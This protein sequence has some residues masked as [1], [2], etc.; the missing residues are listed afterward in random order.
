MAF[1]SIIQ[2]ITDYVCDYKIE[3]EIAINTAYYDLLDSIACALMALKFP[4]CTKLL[5]PI[6]PGASLKNGARVPGTDFELDPV[7]AAFNIGTLIRWLDF[8]DT[9]LAAEWGH[10]SDNLGGILAVCDYLNRCEGKN[11]TVHDI[12]IAMIKAHEIQGVLALDNSFNR[13]GLDHVI[14]VKVATTAVVSHLLGCTRDQINNAVSNAFVDGQS[15]RTYRHAPN[16]GSRKSWAAGD[17][18]SRGVRLAL[19]ARLGEMGY[20]SVLSAKTWGFY[21]VSFKGKPFSLQRPFGTYVMENILFK[22]SFPAEFHAQ[23][24][25]ECAMQLHP[26][27]K[28]KLD[29]IERIEVRTQEPAMRIISKQGPLNNPADRDH[30]LEYMIAVPLIY[31]ELTAEHYE[32]HIAMN[33]QID[34]LRSKMH[35]VEDKQ[36]SVDYLDPEKRSI[37]NAV[38]IVF[39]DGT[40]TEEV[41]IDYP[42]GHKRRRME[43]IPLLINKFEV[44]VKNHYSAEKADQIIT[45]CLDQKRLKLLLASDFTRTL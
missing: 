42:I 25:V 6:V 17:A 26:L 21:D 12:L 27:V 37:G 10:P 32:N 23:T 7:Q 36:M 38:K 8:N 22:I 11:F 3:S 19:M 1:D 13:V 5:G 45:L 40:A 15:L 34:L 2:Q 41:V 44:A 29:Q 43:G 30:C 4:A 33:P 28:D 14:L 18:T 35:V 31:G 16:T 20:P 9:F 39:N 24:A